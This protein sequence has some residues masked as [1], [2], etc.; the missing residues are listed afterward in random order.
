MSSQL[1]AGRENAPQHASPSSPQT[2]CLV[3]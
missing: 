1:T 2:G 3:I